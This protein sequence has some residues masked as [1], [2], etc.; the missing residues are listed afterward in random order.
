M[1]ILYSISRQPWNLKKNLFFHLLELTIPNSFSILASCG[2]KLSHKLFRLTLVRDL[3]QKMGRVP[4]NQ[5]TKQERR[6][7]PINQLN[8]L[9]TR[10]NKHWPLEGRTGCRAC[11]A[12]NKSTKNEIQV[13]RMQHGVVCYPVSR[14]ITPT[15]F[16][17]TNCHYL[18]KWS[19]HTHIPREERGAFEHFISYRYFESGPR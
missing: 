3:I 5:T 9:D 18:E 2:S 14:Y 15:A 1:A 7:P 11:S 6:A 17:R 8:R 16:L 4:Q 13:S 10:H 19:A 12:I